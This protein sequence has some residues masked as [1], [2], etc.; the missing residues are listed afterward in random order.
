MKTLMSATALTA[1]VFAMPALAQAIDPTTGPLVENPPAASDM[2]PG[3]ESGSMSPQPAEPR[4]V[5]P[6]TLPDTSEAPAE[7]LSATSDPMGPA[8]AQSGSEMFVAQQEP[9]TILASSLI[10]TSVTNPAEE[11]LGNINDVVLT[12][13]GA[14]D[15]VVIG[16]GGFLGIGQKAIAVSYPA[17]EKMTDPDGNVVLVL[18]ASQEDLEAAPQYVTLAE[19]RREEEANR[20]A[21]ADPIVPSPGGAQ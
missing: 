12:A 5:G 8:G 19:L 1:L 20:Q 17:I 3:V 4:A 14:V 9:N 16:V 7:P 21:A 15:A 13:D 11:E 6:D 10:G 2:A 18:N